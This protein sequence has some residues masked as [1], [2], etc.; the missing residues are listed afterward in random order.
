MKTLS[1]VVAKVSHKSPIRLFQ[2]LI[3][4]F[5]QI[6]K[7]TY[8]KRRMARSLRLSRAI[9]A[10]VSMECRGIRQIHACSLLQAMTE[11]FECESPSFFLFSFFPCYLL[12]A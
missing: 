10:G 9:T 7:S 1:S 12:S 2:I 8:G 5:L 6:L 4:T 11:K 3:S